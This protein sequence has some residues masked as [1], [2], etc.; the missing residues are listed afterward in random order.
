MEFKKGMQF[1]TDMSWH[2]ESGDIIKV[3]STEYEHP[4]TVVYYYNK[5]K[6]IKSAFDV[7]SRFAKS[8]TRVPKNDLVY[9]VLFIMLAMLLFASFAIG[10]YSYFLSS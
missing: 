5:N 9:R 1:T 10:V 7:N 4:Y 3:I 2:S 6:K 8:L